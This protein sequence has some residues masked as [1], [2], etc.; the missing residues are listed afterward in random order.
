MVIGYREVGPRL[1][2]VALVHGAIH[3]QSQ[4]WPCYVRHSKQ[5]IEISDDV[6]LNDR[7]SL[8]DDLARRASQSLCPRSLPLVPL[9]FVGSVS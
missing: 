2:E 5:R 4:D 8:A 3:A 1:Y 7:E 9:P 6:P